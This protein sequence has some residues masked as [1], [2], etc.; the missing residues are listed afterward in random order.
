VDVG[1]LDRL[2]LAN[3]LTLWSGHVVVNDDGLYFLD[4]SSGVHQLDD[5]VDNWGAT[6]PGDQRLY[7]N[8]TSHIDGAEIY[9]GAYDDQAKQLWAKNTYGQ[10]RIDAADGTGGIAIEGGVLFYAPRYAA[11]QNVVLGFSSGVYAFDGASGADKW[12]QPTTP[13][14]TISVGGGR[15]YLV[16]G[17]N[18]ATKLVARNQSDGAVAWSADVSGASAQAPV[19]ALGKVITASASGVVAFDAASGQSAWTA[20]VQGAAVALGTLTFSGGCAG[21]VPQSIHPQTSMAAALGSSTIV[22]AAFDG[23][24]V[25]SIADGSEAWKGAVPQASGLARNPVLVGKR[26]FVTDATGLVALDAQ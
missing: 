17:D 13:A 21:N 25:L 16:E 11:G 18:G 6:A 15:V 10:C 9:V 23:L 19:L 3:W 7:A 2:D 24:H 26:V 20:N 12:F 1:Q 8:N 5:G 4:P 14:S 22:V